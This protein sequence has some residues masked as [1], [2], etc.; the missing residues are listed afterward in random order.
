MNIVK[1]FLMHISDII[2]LLNIIVELLKSK[3]NEDSSSK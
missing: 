2:N 1:T 3:K